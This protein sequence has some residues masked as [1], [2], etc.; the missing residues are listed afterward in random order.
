MDAVGANQLSKRSLG[1]DAAERDIRFEDHF[2]STK[3]FARLASDDC[4]IVVGAKG[5]GKTA[6]KLALEGAYCA[7]FA[8][9]YAAKLDDLKF[10]PLLG[11]IKKLHMA[12]DH[13]VISIA[14][15]MWRNV[16]A[17]YFL[18]GLVSTNLLINRQRTEIKK[19]L[20]GAGY[21][22]TG[23]GQKMNTHLARVWRLINDWSRDEREGEAPT[24]QNLSP[25]Q[26]AMISAFPSDGKLAALLAKTLE[27]VSK[28]ERP[29]LLCF[30]GLD[31]VVEHTLE[32]RDV[33]FAG[34]IDAACK[35][36]TDPSMRGKIALKILLPKELSYGARV[37]LRDLDKIDEFTE[38]IHW[39]RDNLKEF[40]RRRLE[41]HLR[42]KDRP[43]DE[44]WREYF[45][46]RIR[47][48]A[49]GI[50]EDSFYY[51]LR[52]TMYRPRQLLLQ[53]QWL[54]NKWDLNENAPFRVDPTF[55]VKNV[56]DNNKKLSE[57]VV[58]E[59]RLDFPNLET[60]LR[61]FREVSCVQPWS[62]VKIRI[63]KF[64]GL[65]GMALEAGFTDL[66]NYGFFGVVLPETNDHRRRIARTEFAFMTSTVERNVAVKLTDQS[67]IALAPML[68]EYCGCKTSLIGP[69]VP[70]E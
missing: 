2:V 8:S 31:T 64:L 67:M 28:I 65:T 50:E 47:N 9:V 52:H 11:E 22:G 58:A 13:G 12:S 10:S 3:A 45:P 54:I 32:S 24:P 42:S 51:I 60:F 23:A 18:E 35:T 27:T 62:E 55:I 69:V 39:G 14:R 44:V 29:F 17:I 36:V 7:Q 57:Y 16:I 25:Q 66:Y 26:H 6:L 19:Y 53:V 5:S 48:N 34:L 70:V 30:D 49:H 41:D 40:I 37:H 4:A 56:K 15:A 63:E 46:D 68:A 21:L 43:F 20:H 59:V 38:A 33:I 1:S 61:S